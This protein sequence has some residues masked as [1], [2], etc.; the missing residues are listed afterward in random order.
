MIK[1]G[2]T[3]GIGSG[4]SIVCKV[5]ECLGVSI[6]NADQRAKALMQQD[7]SVVSQIKAAFG[8]A[9]YKDGR[10][11]RDYLA[12][13]VFNDQEQLK[14]LNAIVHPA[15]GRDFESWAME[16]APPYVIKEAALI[17]ESQSHQS[18]NH[19]ICVSAPESLRVHRVLMRDAYRTKAEIQN[20]MSNQLPESE[21]VNMADYVI[22]NDD[23]QMVV[24]QILKIHH[25]FD[26]S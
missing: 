26:N 14:T 21:K 5:F 15:V 4:K 17:F 23:Q 13:K 12:E 8:A 22:I 7:E 18:L 24:P 25:Q 6:Y 2:V 16:Q 11:N 20:I 19:V 1:I 9:S 3:G 10:L